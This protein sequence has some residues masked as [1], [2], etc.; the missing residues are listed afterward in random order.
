MIPS[1]A[2][3]KTP[4]ASGGHRVYLPRVHAR[5]VYWAYW[6][7][8]RAQWS[9]PYG[10]SPGHQEPLFVAMERDGRLQWSDPAVRLHW[11]ESADHDGSDAH[12][13]RAL[14]SGV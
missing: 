7:N 11:I 4:M 8:E 6:S 2:T 13:E 10:G 1:N 5:T 3:N 12:L 14:R 9:L